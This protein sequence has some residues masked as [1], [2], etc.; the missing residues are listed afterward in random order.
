[1]PLRIGC[2]ESRTNR[3]DLVSSI[4]ERKKASLKIENCKI[5]NVYTREIIDGDIIVY[6]DRLGFVGDC[7]QFD[8]RKV[9]D[10][11]G[12]YAT[13]GLMD[14]HVHIDTCVLNPTNFARAVLPLG[15]TSIFTDAHEIGNALGYKGVKLLIEEGKQTPLRIFEWIPAQVPPGSTQ[16]QTPN[17]R[18]GLKETK[19][20]Y[21]DSR[22]IGLGEVSKYRVLSKD[23]YFLDKIEW[24]LQNGGLVNASAHEFSGLKL[25]AYLSSGLF[26]DH[27]SVTREMILER[28]RCGIY[29]F[30][31]EGTTE[32]NLRETVKAITEDEVDSSWFCFCTD[33]CYPTSLLTNGHIDNCLR[34]A[35]ACG[36][37]PIVAV[38]MATINCARA[39]HIDIEIGGLAPGKLADIVLVDDLR[40]YRPRLVI[41][42][43]QVVADE[44]GMTTDLPRPR[45]PTRFLHSVRIERSL[46]DKDV[47]IKAPILDGDATVRVI[48]A[49][50]GTIWSRA[51]TENLNV[52]DGIVMSSVNDDVQK[53]VVVERYGR[54]RGPR[55]GKG[56]IRG[57]KFKTGAIAESKAQD[58]HD[59]V[60]TGTNDRDIAAAINRVIVLQGGLAVAKDGVVLGSFDTPIGGII[61][62]EPVS[63]V[64]AEIDVLCD[65]TRSELGSLL[66]N[67]FATLEFQTHPGIPELKITDKGLVD[68]VAQKVV[69]L[70][71]TN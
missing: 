66:T 46:R 58:K 42:G 61:S 35:I 25:Q 6:G 18:I 15:T 47:R 29:V 41:A 55:I 1:M 13:P 8:A 39:M 69:P 45:Y 65:K 12:R 9:I 60:A 21:K 56:F 38:Q 43:G 53:V 3:S 33:D 23:R 37:D 59:I 26:G 30:V 2:L 34:T 68:S 14:A 62:E 49:I 4:I 22:V 5:V 32:K 17:E 57:F 19:K 54:T 63:K 10:G 70:F 11:K 64:A 52:E 71:L 36:V 67:P 40:E 16:V 44:N 51:S 20:L 48:E 31:R 50:E 24:I 28:V 7:S 27:E